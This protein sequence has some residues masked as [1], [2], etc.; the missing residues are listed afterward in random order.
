MYEAL[1]GAAF[2]AV[3]GALG[4]RALGALDNIGVILQWYLRGM[5]FSFGAIFYD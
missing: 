3:I 5:L 1:N 2:I 4:G